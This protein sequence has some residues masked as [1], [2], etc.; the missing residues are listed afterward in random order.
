MVVCFPLVPFSIDIEI[1]VKTRPDPV[2]WDRLPI[3]LR[4]GSVCRHLAVLYLSKD[5]PAVPVAI[6]V[7]T[8]SD[9]PRAVRDMAQAGGKLP[10]QIDVFVD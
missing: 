7:Q 6:A 3:L 8:E 2:R 5:W 9:K 4:V 10:E 1:V